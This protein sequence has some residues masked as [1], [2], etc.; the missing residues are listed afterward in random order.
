MNI[1]DLKLME[2]HCIDLLV[3]SLQNFVLEHGEEMC[4]YYRDEHGIDEENV[5]KVLDLACEGCHFAVP[6]KY[7]AEDEDDYEHHAFWTLYVV[8]DENDGLD[9]KYYQFYNTGL[10]FSD[11]DSEPDHD[12]ARSLSLAELEFIYSHVIDVYK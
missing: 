1:N 12:Y 2:Q 6:I 5:V 3:A 4:D 10:T 7:R 9:L 8:S 11:E